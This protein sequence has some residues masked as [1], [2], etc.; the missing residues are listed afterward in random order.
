ML[1][2]TAGTITQYQDIDSGETLQAVPWS[3]TEEDQELLS[4]VQSF[5]LTATADE[6]TAF[7]ARRLQVYQDD[8][9]R[10][11]EAQAHQAD[12]DHAA[13]VA[14]EMSGISISET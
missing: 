14:E 10:F 6:I 3:V 2:I 5:P 7:L 12:L 9:A 11:E 4:G 1:T 8:A 13:G